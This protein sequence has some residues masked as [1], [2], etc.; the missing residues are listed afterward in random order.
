M[1]TLREAADTALAADMLRSA[2]MSRAEE[3]AIVKAE[4]EVSLSL[5]L[6]LAKRMTPGVSQCLRFRIPNI[7]E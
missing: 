6:L 5:D 1:L 3:E 7:C 2:S 4:A